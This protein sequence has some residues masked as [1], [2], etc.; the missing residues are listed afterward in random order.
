MALYL[1]QCFCYQ[2]SKPFSNLMSVKWHFIF[3]Y[4]FLMTSEAKHLSCLLL[5]C[6]SSS[7]S[8]LP[9]AFVLYWVVLIDFW[10]FF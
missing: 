4:I 9:L 6:I 5:I 7:L 2:I 10:K 1:H 3:I 8:Y